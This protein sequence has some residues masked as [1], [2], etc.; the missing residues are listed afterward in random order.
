MLCVEACRTATDSAMREPLPLLGRA[1]SI[2]PFAAT[3]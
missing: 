2:S 3:Y 1:Y